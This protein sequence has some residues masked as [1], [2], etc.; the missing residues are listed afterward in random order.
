MIKLLIRFIVKARSTI[1]WD[2]LLKT[3]LSARLLVPGP[4]ILIILCSE[5][6]KICIYS[7][8]VPVLMKQD[9]LDLGVSW[10]R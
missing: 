9:V 4:R 3:F 7:Y 10:I 2:N 8:L 6:I 1:H 5:R